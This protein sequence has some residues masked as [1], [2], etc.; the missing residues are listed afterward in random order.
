MPCSL[1]NRGR[2]IRRM[3]LYFKIKEFN[4]CIFSFA[5]S[6]I[7]KDYLIIRSTNIAGHHCAKPRFFT[8][9]ALAFILGIL[10][11]ATLETGG[12][13]VTLDTRSPVSSSSR[14]DNFIEIAWHI[15]DTIETFIVYMLSVE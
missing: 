1:G 12:G 6:L 4:S 3:E 14:E 2:I 10:V 9:R 13:R 11:S 7:R 5:P 15:D 8:N